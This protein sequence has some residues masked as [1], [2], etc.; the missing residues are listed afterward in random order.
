VEYLGGEITVTVVSFT[1]WKLP[2]GAFHGA[3][4]IGEDP[5]DELLRSWNVRVGDL[6]ALN[7]D[8]PRRRPVTTQIFSGKMT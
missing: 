5:Q 1:D 2:N 8:R 3:R 7:A 6:P 4:M